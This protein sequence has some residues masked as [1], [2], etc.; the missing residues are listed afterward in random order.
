MITIK[1]TT[2]NDFPIDRQLPYNDPKF[3]NVKFVINQNIAE[4]D[5]WIVY[6]N[7]KTSETS[8]CPIENTFLFTGEPSTVRSYN[9]KFINQFGN[10]ITSQ[11][12]LSHPNK[13]YSQ[14]CLPWLVGISAK[15]D[16]HKFLNSNFWR[17]EDFNS[18][19]FSK[20]N[21]LISVITSNKTL[22]K[23]HRQRLKFVFEL[24]KVLGNDLEI[25]G[26]G[27]NSV[28]DKMDALKEFKYTVVL[29]NSQHNDYWTEKI[30]DAFLCE[31]F[32][33]YYGC[34]NIGKYFDINSLTSINIKHSQESIDAVLKSIKL[35]LYETNKDA[36]MESKNRVLNEYNLFNFILTLTKNNNLHKKILLTFNPE[37]HSFVDKFKTR[38]RRVI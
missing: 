9:R 26:N 10:L 27:F 15:E 7:L 19:T 21:R 13:R 22:T 29:E 31:C 24:K 33:I 28:K 4:C 11:T 34:Q 1:I 30:A 2:P 37:E 16:H 35:N 38:L 14:T 17:Y 18:N 32:P 25:F 8:L 12:D 6:D 3:H 5:Y 23:G 36:I 20:K